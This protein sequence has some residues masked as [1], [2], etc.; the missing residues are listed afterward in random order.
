MS[1]RLISYSQPANIIGVD[2]TQDLV[3]YCARVSN[4]SNQNNKETNE[5]LIRYL[6]KHGHW[7]PL[8][9]ASVC[10]EIT[11]TRDIAHQIVR[12]RSFAF[13]EFSQRYANPEEMGDMYVPR[14]AR[15]Q[16]GKNRQNSV[17]LDEN[18]ELN[19]M[20]LHFQKEI[21]IYL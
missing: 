3:A 21:A 20:W 4:P 12:H 1:V 5:K 8:E 18:S 10:L 11:T 19:Q 2:N 9:M 16:D 17:D 13:Q 6:I 15:L 14:E 7:S